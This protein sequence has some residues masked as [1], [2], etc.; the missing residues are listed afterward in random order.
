MARKPRRPFVYRLDA[1]WAAKAMGLG[2]DAVRVAM[3]IAFRAGLAGN[4]RDV[5]PTQ[6]DYEFF[7]VARWQRCRGIQALE[8]A[9]LIRKLN[10]GSNELPKVEIVLPPECDT[11]DE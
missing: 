3:A 5:R 11:A 7:G 2:L 6:R 8:A 4:E 1:A 9:G 10:S